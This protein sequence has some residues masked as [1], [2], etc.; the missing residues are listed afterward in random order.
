MPPQLLQVLARLPPPRAAQSRR[1][2]PSRAG[3]ASSSSDGVIRSTQASQR[4]TAARSRSSTC[5]SSSPS[6]SR[7][8]DR[9]G[10]HP[11]RRYARRR[12]PARGAQPRRLTAARSAS[13]EAPRRADWTVGSARYRSSATASCIFVG[14]EEAET[15]VDVGRHAAPLERRLELAMAVARSEQ[16]GD[17][18]RLGRPADAG[19]AIAHRRVGEQADDLVRDRSAGCRS[20][21]YRRR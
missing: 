19:R 13:A 12:R 1:R 3:R 7:A 16:N 21:A 6:G 2:T 9:A 17:V 15:F 18:R 11:A 5:R 4:G 20:D 10:E 14:V 8:D